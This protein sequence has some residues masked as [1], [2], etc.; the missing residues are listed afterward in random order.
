[1]NTL[2]FRMLLLV[3]AVVIL[4]LLLKKYD[5]WTKFRL[6]MMMLFTKLSVGP[7]KREMFDL[8]AFDDICDDA[9]KKEYKLL[10]G[11]KI[12][13]ERLKRWCINR[14]KV[15]LGD[16]PCN[17]CTIKSE[18]DKPTGCTK[19]LHNKL[20]LSCTSFDNIRCDVCKDWEDTDDFKYKMGSDYQDYMNKTVTYSSS[21]GNNQVENKNTNGSPTASSTLS[22]SLNNLNTILTQRL[23]ENT[24]S[25]SSNEVTSST[26]VLDK[27][28]E[29]LAEGDIQ[30]VNS[31]RNFSYEGN[32]GH[33]LPVDTS[34]SQLT[35]GNTMDEYSKYRNYL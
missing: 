5:G 12:N 3:L 19:K 25:I 14:S 7:S 1:M 28:G 27:L 35:G 33:A 4:G 23:S 18:D 10:Y 6:H 11:E 22:N 30:E 20:V 31:F 16:N 17:G 29:L 15:K 2:Y 9:Q 21:D 32:V 26:S 8:K 24:L 34:F 13:E